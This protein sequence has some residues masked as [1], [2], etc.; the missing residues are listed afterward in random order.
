[1]VARLAPPF[2]LRLQKGKLMK[3]ATDKTEPIGELAIRV[4]AMPE[5][6]NPAGD[7]FGGWVLS[8]MDIAG[9]AVSKKHTKG[10]TVTVAV[11]S[12]VF[13]KPVLVGDIL[14][15]YVE[16]LKVGRTSIKVNIETWVDRQYESIRER[17]TEGI[18]TYVAVCPKGTPRV[19]A[20][21]TESN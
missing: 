8:Q 15:C 3:T 9:G 7:I 10:R 18:F 5:N 11:E 1:M 6:T 2:T 19:I 16:V 17:V 4:L 14:C 13:H 21:P 12:M 20:E